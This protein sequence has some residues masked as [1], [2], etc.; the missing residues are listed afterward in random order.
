[1]EGREFRD[2]SRRLA[3]F[4]FGCRRPAPYRNPTAV[5]ALVE[6]GELPHVRIGNV[7]RIHPAD[8]SLVLQRNRHE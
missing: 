8:L 2:I 5:Y 6:S 7:V 4:V 3:A 1:M